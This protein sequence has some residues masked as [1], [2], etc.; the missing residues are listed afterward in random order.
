M[1]MEVEDGCKIYIIPSQCNLSFGMR[2]ATPSALLTALAKKGKKE[3]LK[4]LR[5]FTCVVVVRRV[6]SI[7]M[8]PN[9]LVLKEQFCCICEDLR[10][11]MTLKSSS[12][13]ITVILQVANPN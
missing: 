11:A 1:N 5:F 2:A 8:A 3:K 13:A 10:L 6:V 9:L 12:S 7:K 4:E